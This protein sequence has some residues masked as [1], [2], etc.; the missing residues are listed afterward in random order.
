MISIDDAL[1]AY[2][3]ELRALPPESISLIEAHGRTLAQGVYSPTDLPRFD[4][5]AMDG[6]TFRAADVAEATPQRPVRLPLHLNLAAKG[7]DALPSLTPATAARIFTGAPLP[8]GADAMIPQERATRDGNTLLFTAPWPAHLNIGRRAEELRSGSQLAD[9]GSR[10]DAGLLAA[11]ANAS[12][13]EVMVHRRPRIRLLTT[14]DELRPIGTPLRLGEIHDSNGPM[15]R[16][17]LCGWGYDVAAADHVG[18]RPEAVERALDQAFDQADL[19]LSAGGASVGDHDHLPAT[20]EKLGLR[21]V[22]WQVAQKPGKPLWFGVG[23]RKARPLAMLALPGNPGAVLI[24]LC[25]HV[26]RVLD[27]LEGTTLPAP[28]WRSGVLESAVE[29]DPRRERLLRMAL[30]DAGDGRVLLRPLANQDSHMLG[31]LAVARVLVR[32]SAGDSP[33]A[34]GEVLP[35]IALPT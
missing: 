15:M 19:V 11:L 21:R 27:L 5:S 7:T 16:A 12:I 20:A 30:H 9:A 24:G 14:G 23:E 3:R 32:V 4:Q 2:V 17:V 13:S 1:A 28:R 10:I 8:A 35:W 26:A 33:V 18:D 31:N 22:F 34:S 25:L 6:Y 29:R